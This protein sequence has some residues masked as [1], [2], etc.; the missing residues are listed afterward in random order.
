[1]VGEFRD[2]RGVFFGQETMDGRPIFVRFVISD[3]TPDSCR[4]EQAFSLDGGATWEVNW[5]AVDTR[6]PDDAD[7]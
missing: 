4:F 5:V 6:V 2:G 7:D 3:V 1:M